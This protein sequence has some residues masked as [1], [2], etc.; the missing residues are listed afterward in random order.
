[1]NK[2]SA[3][4]A[5]IGKYWEKNDIQA[6]IAPW[7][8]AVTLIGQLPAQLDDWHEK[9]VVQ[10]LMTPWMKAFLKLLQSGQ[11]TK[12]DIT[13]YYVEKNA[14]LTALQTLVQKHTS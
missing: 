1:M 10:Y 3:I 12:Q 9:V 2:L 11:G 13:V 7:E 14:I 6:T 4:A 5:R 8:Q